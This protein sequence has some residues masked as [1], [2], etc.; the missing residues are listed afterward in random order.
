MPETGFQAIEAPFNTIKLFDLDNNV[1]EYKISK[2]SGGHGGGDE[3]LLE[4]LFRGGVPDP[5]GHAAGVKAGTDSIMIGVAANTSIREQRLV[6]I[7]DL[8]KRPR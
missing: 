8:L 1:T 2:D 7:D 6:D 5:L 4:T 3:R